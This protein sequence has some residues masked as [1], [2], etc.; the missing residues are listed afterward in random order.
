M[1]RRLFTAVRL[2]PDLVAGLERLREEHG[3]TVAESIRRAVRQ[4]LERKGV[5]E[6]TTRK[7]AATRKRV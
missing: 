2:D 7:R 5:I 6:K 1:T 4:Y 3:P